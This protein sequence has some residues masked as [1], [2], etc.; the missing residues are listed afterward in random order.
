MTKLVGM[1]R[2]AE[3]RTLEGEAAEYEDV[4]AELEAQVPEGWEIIQFQTAK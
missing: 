4:R 2:S 1:I 3:R